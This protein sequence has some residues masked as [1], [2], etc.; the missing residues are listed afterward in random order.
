MIESTKI[1][2]ECIW[3]DSDGITR[4]TDP[5]RYENKEEAELAM[6]GHTIH[7]DSYYDQ[8]RDKENTKVLLPKGKKI[9]QR[10]KIHP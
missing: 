10:I 7:F 5:V 6:E 4:R 2:A 8:A 9:S 1:F 3:T